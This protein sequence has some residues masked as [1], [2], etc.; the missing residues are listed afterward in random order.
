MRISE[1]EKTPAFILFHNFFLISNN[2][3][4]W[5][6][7][8]PMTFCPSSTVPGSWLRPPP[9]GRDRRTA[10]SRT[11]RRTTFS[12]SSTEEDDVLTSLSDPLTTLGDPLTSLG[13]KSYP[14]SGVA[15]AGTEDIGS[16]STLQY[17]QYNK[18]FNSS[19]LKY[20]QN[21]AVQYSTLEYTKVR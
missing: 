1:Y 5:T 4:S 3:F 21:E 20:G 18:V 19:T 17:G 6:I 10:A 9:Q 14:C 7:W 12:H 2:F 16:G 15:S 8:T 11:R 13:A